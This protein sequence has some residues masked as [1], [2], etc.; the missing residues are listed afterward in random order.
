MGNRI[1]PSPC[2]SGK[3]AVEIKKDTT[4]RN[5]VL[6]EI[7]KSKAAK[8]SGKTR[9]RKSHGKRHL[10]VDEISR[11]KI[12]ADGKKAIREIARGCGTCKGNG[13]VKVRIENKPVEMQPCPECA[14]AIAVN[15]PM[16]AVEA[17]LRKKAG[18]D[19]K[20]AASLHQALFNP[21]GGD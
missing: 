18:H 15:Q 5:A 12:M 16:T 13:L 21:E 17:A 20:S 4:E 8:Q 2:R 9:L 6:A 1:G 3:K 7:A 14:Q 19:A 11:L 10:S